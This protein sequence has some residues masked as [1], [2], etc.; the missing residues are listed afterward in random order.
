MQGPSG[1]KPPY[2]FVSSVR[3]FSSPLIRMGPSLVHSPAHFSFP[4][5]TQSRTKA[6]SVVTAEGG[7]FGG[8][9]REREGGQEG[10]V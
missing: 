3:T 1:M 9:G 5:A 10:G 7:K 6:A 8:D 4:S 2:L